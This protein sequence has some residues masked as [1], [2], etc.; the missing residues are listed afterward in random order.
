M[1]Q[2]RR[3]HDVSLVHGDARGDAFDS[4]AARAFCIEALSGDTLKAFT[5]HCGAQGARP[6]PV[7]QELQERMPVVGRHGDLQGRVPRALLRGKSTARD[8]LKSSATS[9]NSRSALRRTPRLANALIM[10]R[11]SRA[12]ASACTTSIRSARF[13]RLASRTFRAWFDRHQGSTDQTQREVVLFPDTFTNFFEPEVAI[14]ATEVLERANFR[15]VIPAM[16]YVAGVRSMTRGCSIARSSGCRKSMDALWPMVERGAYVVGLEPSCILT[17]RDELPALFPDDAR[18]KILR[19]RAL[20]LDEF[21]AREVSGYIPPQPKPL[22]VK[23]ML[24]GHCHQKAIAGLD[25]E[26]SILSRI[27]DSNVEVLDAGCCG[28]AGPFGYE[29]S[30]F[31]V[32]K[33]CADRVL[34]P[35]INAQRRE[36]HRDLGRLF[37]P[38]ANPPILSRPPSDASRAVLSCCEKCKL[39]PRNEHVLH[40]ESRESCAERPAAI[41]LVARTSVVSRQHRCGR[42]ANRPYKNSEKMEF[43]TPSSSRRDGRARSAPPSGRSRGSP[44]STPSPCRSDAR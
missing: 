31:A 27:R 7:V 6:L 20:L 12:S 22:K 28:M 5:D 34:V 35:A 39:L 43:A 33:A 1:P 9:T 3:R 11:C 8:L 29:D 18:A 21:L 25:T 40:C 14:A 44:S 37:M 32:S 30:H 24:H 13:P 10:R 15:V 19:E 4:R 16:T 42:F 26:T 17:F 23:A 2:D 41:D 36:T 38:F